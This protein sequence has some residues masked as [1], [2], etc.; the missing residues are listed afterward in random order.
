MNTYTHILALLCFMFFFTPLNAN[1][2]Y[3]ISTLYLTLPHY[4]A[5]EASLSGQKMKQHGDVFVAEG[6]APGKYLLKVSHRQAFHPSMATNADSYEIIFYYGYIQI[7]PKK[8]IVAKLDS[9]KHLQIL[10]ERNTKTVSIESQPYS[11]Q[12]FCLL[13]DS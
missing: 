10:E 11:Q 12:G 13:Q 8:V 7:A 3:N 1:D 5:V 6:I 4:Q 2:N 9:S